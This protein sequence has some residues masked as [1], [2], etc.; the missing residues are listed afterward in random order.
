MKWWNK[1]TQHDHFVSAND[2]LSVIWESFCNEVVAGWSKL[3]CNQGCKTDLLLCFR[4][5]CFVTSRA[6]ACHVMSV[7]HCH[8]T[9]VGFT[10]ESTVQC[11]LSVLC[12]VQQADPWQASSRLDVVKPAY[13]WSFTSSDSFH[14]TCHHAAFCVVVWKSHHEPKVTAFC[15]LAVLFLHWPPCRLALWSLA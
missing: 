9:M 4:C 15:D 12:S 3:S 13:S 8:F 10:W 2:R 14:K 1:F 6:L 11:L 5:F 7:C